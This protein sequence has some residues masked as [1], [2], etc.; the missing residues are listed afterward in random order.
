MGVKLCFVAEKFCVLS[1]DRNPME[2][3]L[4]S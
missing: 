2:G 1:S 3:V 4:V